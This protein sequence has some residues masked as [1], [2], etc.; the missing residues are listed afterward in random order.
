MR[1]PTC[2]PIY[3]GPDGRGVMNRGALR[4]IALIASVGL[5]L[6]GCAPQFNTV[7]Q[8][9]TGDLGWVHSF[10]ARFA[11]SDASIQVVQ[12]RDERRP[13]SLEQAPAEQ[14]MDVYDPDT[15]L[16]GVEPR[17]HALYEKYLGFKP[18]LP[19]HYL[20]EIKLIELHTDV[21][22]GDFWSG[23]FGRYNV[24]LEIE[25]TA[26]RPDSTVVLVRRYPFSKTERR[27]TY[28]GRSPSVGMDETR[29]TALVEEGVRITAMDFAGQ[30]QR[31]DWRWRPVS[32]NTLLP[33]DKIRLVPQLSLNR[34]TAAH[35]FD[36]RKLALST[37]PAASIS[38]T[39]APDSV[40]ATVAPSST[41]F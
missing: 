6:A 13:R 4:R 5:L 39:Y 40:S 30:L 20:V 7:P 41:N 31:T 28:N 14:A 9:E 36:E 25:A 33:A 21:L 8:P 34:P 3:A 35:A 15:L 37:E 23:P 16:A 32:D 19:K 11:R 18:R 1:T 2:Y 10:T 24:K 38:P 12:V 29:L 26:R 17:L 22:N 27:R